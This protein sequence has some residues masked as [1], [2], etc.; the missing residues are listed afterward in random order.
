ML[1]QEPKIKHITEN[2]MRDNYNWACPVQ[3]FSF[4]S[5]FQSVSDFL[6]GNRLR[7]LSGRKTKEHASELQTFTSK[8]SFN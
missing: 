5:T 6:P 2:N 7:D 1:T 4:L 8:T 3:H